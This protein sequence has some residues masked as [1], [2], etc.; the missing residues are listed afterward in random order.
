[1]NIYSPPPHKPR[2]KVP[3]PRACRRC[4]EQYQ[5]LPTR[6]F[7]QVYCSAKCRIKD[8]RARAKARR[9]APAD[10]SSCV[11]CQA[12]VPPRTGRGGYPKKYCG[13]KCASRAGTARRKAERRSR[14]DLSPRRCK[15]CT[16]A[17]VPEWRHQ[18]LC[19]DICRGANASSATLEHSRRYYIPAALQPIRQCEWCGD[20]FRQRSA[21][22][23]YCCSACR[24]DDTAYRHAED[25]G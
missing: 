2:G 5:P 13:S 6:H 24:K 15:M 14:M 9:P 4:G 7:E 18:V 1:M 3:A 21:V 11:V 17:F 19:D 16:R 12:P 8:N 23:R 10:A 25:E 20:D 22:T